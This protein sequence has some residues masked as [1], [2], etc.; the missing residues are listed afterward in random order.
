MTNEERAASVSEALHNFADAMGMGISL[1]SDG[2]VTVAGD[3]ICSILHWVQEQ[4]PDGKFAA[5]Q[6]ARSGLGHY[7]TEA[8]NQNPDEDPVGPD[9]F[10]MIRVDCDGLSWEA[11]PGSVSISEIIP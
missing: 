8:S 4:A 1:D 3:M 2:P 9:A 11:E 5:L 6:A 7:V 10:V